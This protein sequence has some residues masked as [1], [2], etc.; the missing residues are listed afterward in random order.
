MQN[1]HLLH[2]EDGTVLYLDD[3]G[4]GKD[5]AN[6]LVFLGCPSCIWHLSFH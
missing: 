2:T 5:V 6:I 4:K 1:E 3:L